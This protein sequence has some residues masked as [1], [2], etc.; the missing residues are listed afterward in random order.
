MRSCG[1]NVAAERDG[2]GPN[3]YGHSADGCPGR[4]SATSKV[5]PGTIPTSPIHVDTSCF[6]D[7][8]TPNRGSLEYSCGSFPVFTMGVQDGHQWGSPG[9]HV[10]WSWT[11]SQMNPAVASRSTA[12]RIRASVSTSEARTYPG[13]SNASPG[14]SPTPASRTASIHHCMSSSVSIGIIA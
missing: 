5:V 7:P 3:E 8:P 1:G 6:H 14:T 2:Q 13:V 12:S 10:P 11:D 4:S 9:A